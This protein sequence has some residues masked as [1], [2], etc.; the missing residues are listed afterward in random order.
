[1]RIE[2]KSK[3]KITIKEHVE[4]SA[5]SSLNLVR[6]LDPLHLS[7][8]LD[9]YRA[10]VG[11]GNIRANER[12]S[13]ARTQRFA[14]EKVIEPPANVPRTRACHRTPPGVMTATLLELAEGI[15]EAGV[16]QG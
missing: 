3:K 12:A 16:Y 15:Q 6:N 9:P 7:M 1:M 5:A 13:E 10:M 8:N 4:P 14:Q 11:T 2:I